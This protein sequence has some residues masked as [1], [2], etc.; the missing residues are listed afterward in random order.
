MHYG[1]DYEIMCAIVS[2]FVLAAFIPF[3]SV[4]HQKRSLTAGQV[5][6]TASIELI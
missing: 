3:H 6:Q 2:T 4:R 5:Y 1:M